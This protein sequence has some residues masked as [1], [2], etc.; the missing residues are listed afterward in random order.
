VGELRYPIGVTSRQTDPPRDR[1]HSVAC[2]W[3]R[4]YNQYP[5]AHSAGSLLLHA[6]A[7]AVTQAVAQ[8]VART[9]LGGGRDLDDIPQNPVGR[10]IGALDGAPLPRQAQHLALV[11]Q[12]GELPARHLVQQHLRVACRG[13]AGDRQ[14]IG[15]ALMKT[16]ARILCPFTKEAKLATG[17]PFRTIHRSLTEARGRCCIRGSLRLT[18]EL[19]AL[20]WA[21]HIASLVPVL[22]QARELLDVQACT[23]RT[24][25]QERRHTRVGTGAQ[26]DDAGRSCSKK[27]FAIAHE[28]PAATHP[29]RAPC[30]A[31]TPP[32]PPCWADS[33]CRSWRRW[34]SPPRPRRPSRQR[35]WR[36]RP[37]L[38]AGTWG[39]VRL[40]REHSR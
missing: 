21:V 2:H 16:G 7:H 11:E 26:E 20:E 22:V 24:M 14:Y 10:S 15:A 23:W 37:C 33:W 30:P 17:H 8:G 19:P 36:R 3:C 29:C 34:R 27:H 32:A 39:S 25:M 4:L 5:R 9:H 12:V 35:P 28:L 40:A 31:A 6:V 18:C 38:Q 1:R 13:G